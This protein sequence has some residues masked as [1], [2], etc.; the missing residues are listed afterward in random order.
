MRCLV[1]GRFFMTRKGHK[2]IRPATHRSI[3]RTWLQ[4]IT[5]IRWRNVVKG[6]PLIGIGLMIRRKNIPWER[7]TFRISCGNSRMK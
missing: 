2:V 4:E 5:K 3:I 1:P 7:S 6:I